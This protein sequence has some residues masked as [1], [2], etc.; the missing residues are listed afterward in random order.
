[1]VRLPENVR[2][3]QGEKIYVSYMKT[4]MQANGAGLIWYRCSKDPWQGKLEQ[5]RRAIGAGS[6]T[7]GKSGKSG[8]WGKDRLGKRR[9]D[10]KYAAQLADSKKKEK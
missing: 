1:M 4:R 8:H 10:K 9:M 5:T 2:N 6:H 3:P 7:V